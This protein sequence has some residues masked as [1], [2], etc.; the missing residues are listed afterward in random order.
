MAADLPA[1]ADPITPDGPTGLLD[2][3]I[4]AE[5]TLAMTRGAGV[6]RSAASLRETVR[7]LDSLG[8]A[9]CTDPGPDSWEVTD[10]HTVATALASAAAR[11]EETRGCH[12]REDFAEPR[13]DWCGHLLTAIGSDGVLREDFEPLPAGALA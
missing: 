10:L 1:Q 5:L 2:A 13:E 6:L 4:R 7:T 8:A 11:R 9:G 3:G 12:W